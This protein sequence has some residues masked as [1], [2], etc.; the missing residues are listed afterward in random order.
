MWRVCW[1]PKELLPSQEGLYCMKLSSQSV[2]YLS[3]DIQFLFLVF[4]EEVLFLC[5]HKHRTLTMLFSIMQNISS[6]LYTT[7]LELLLPGAAEFSVSVTKWL[8]GT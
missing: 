1:L 3:L 4:T 5:T 6:S 2:C 7:I 8:T